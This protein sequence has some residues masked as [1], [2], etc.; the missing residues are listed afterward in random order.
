MRSTAQQTAAKLLVALI[1]LWASSGC[2]T[3]EKLFKPKA[4]N[5]QNKTAKAPSTKPNSPESARFVHNV[6]WSGET[7]SLISKWYTGSYQNWRALADANPRLNPNRIK[8]GDEIIIPKNILKTKKSM[9]RSFVPTA[10]AGKRKVPVEQEEPDA[11]AVG[12]ELFEP[13]E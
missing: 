11:D 5:V 13:K 9:P 12:L 4:E 3:F 1:L 6:R 2:A 8:I 10:S 7:L